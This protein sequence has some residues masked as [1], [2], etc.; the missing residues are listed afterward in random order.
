MQTWKNVRTNHWQAA[1]AWKNDNKDP[2]EESATKIYANSAEQTEAYA[3]L[4][5]V[6]DME[7]R[8]AGLIIKSD[9]REVILALKGQNG[10]NKNIKNIIKDIKRIANSFLFV[11]CIKVRR[12]EVTLGHNLAIKARKS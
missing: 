8:S 11:S 10:A 12:E 5:A 7:W 9:N 6:S 1:I 2:N 4:K 3:I